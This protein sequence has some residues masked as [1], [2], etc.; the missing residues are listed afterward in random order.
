MIL[1]LRKGERAIKEDNIIIN[2]ILF[3]LLYLLLSICFNLNHFSVWSSDAAEPAA[4]GE[5][6]LLQPRQQRGRVR[7][8]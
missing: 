5:G 4:L 6:L 7:P 2:I 8:L 1:Q 3:F